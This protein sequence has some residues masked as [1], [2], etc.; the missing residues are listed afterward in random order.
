[1]AEFRYLGMT[2]TNQIFI[3]KEITHKLNMENAC[4]LWFQKLFCVPIC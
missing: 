3:L 1:M 4:Y 2:V